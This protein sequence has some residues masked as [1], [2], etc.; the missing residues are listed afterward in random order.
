MEQEK[1]YELSDDFERDIIRAIMTDPSILARAKTI[2]KPEYFNNKPSYSNAYCIEQ[3]QEVYDKFNYVINLELLNNILHHYNPQEIPVKPFENWNKIND[4]E[5]MLAKIEHFCRHRACITAS[6]NVYEKISKGDTKG[7]VEMMENA[8]MVKLPSN[9]GTEIFS[10][11]EDVYTELINLHQTQYELRTGWNE[12]DRGLSGGFGY[13]EVNVF[14][15]PSGMG[16][17]VVMANLALNYA[18]QGLNV[19]YFSL[20]LNEILTKKRILSMLTGFP[21]RSMKNN[22]TAVMESYQETMDKL[23]WESCGD[24]RIIQVPNSSTTMQ[25]EA[26]INEYELKTGR[27]VN[28]IVVDYADLMLSDRKVSRENIHLSEKF[29][30]EELRNM[31][32]KRTNAGRK[33]TI[34]TASQLG[35]GSLGTDMSEWDQSSLAG[36]AGKNF[37]CDNLISIFASDKLKQEGIIKLKFFKTRNSYYTKE[38]ELS[39]NIDTL[40][41]DNQDLKDSK[42]P[43][44]DMFLENMQSKVVKD[45]TPTNDT[46]KI[47]NLINNQ[48]T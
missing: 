9:F 28:I 43:E 5:I 41:V 24:F 27:I 42:N 18:K 26:I 20:E 1:E 48:T 4:S 40:R 44:M 46:N 2:L 29:V 15:A 22:E 39:Y 10:S 36:S 33:S 38:I 21:I 34:I 19:L 45:M 32:V 8:L 30:Y 11:A 3:L 16:K 25:L 7:V 13:G 14:S 35:K 23:G 12:L 31:V 37:T 17:S 6:L 47:L